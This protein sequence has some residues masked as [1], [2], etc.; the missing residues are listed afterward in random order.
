MNVRTRLDN[1]AGF[2]EICPGGRFQC[3]KETVRQSYI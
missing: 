1:R 2:W 3:Q